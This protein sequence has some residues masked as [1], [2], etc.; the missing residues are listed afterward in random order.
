VNKGGYE[1]RPA[2]DSSRCITDVGANQRV[3]LQSCTSAATQVWQWV[4]RR[5]VNGLSY[6]FWINA[7]TNRKLTFD[8]FTNEGTFPSFTVIA[9][10]TNYNAGTAG[11]ATQLWAE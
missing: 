7:Q 1:L 8:T 6:Q 11:E 3:Q 4:P 9:S 10:T 2:G 5:T